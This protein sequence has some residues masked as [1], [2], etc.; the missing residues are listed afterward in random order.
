MGSLRYLV[1]LGAAVASSAAQA[2]LVDCRPPEQAP[3][4]VYLSEPEYTSTAFRNRPEMLGFFNR[5]HDYL[6]QRRDQ[7]MMGIAAVNFRVAR[8][9]GRVPAIDGS[10]FTDR[11]IRSMDG[12][13]VVVEVWGALD[14]VRAP[15]QAPQPTAQMN[16]LVVPVKR[17]RVP[18]SAS[19][20]GI[21]RFHYPDGSIVAADF[22][23][24]ISN[25]DLHAFV[26]AA[27]GVTAFDGDEYPLA[28]EMLCKARSQLLVTE[29]RLAA[30]AASQQQGRQIASLRQLL[31][32]LAR[33]SIESAR[34]RSG[35]PPT[36][37]VLHEPAEP[38]SAR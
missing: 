33:K 35:T 27:I 3:F 11:V 17:G 13:N 16:Y 6:D 30:R 1:V 26:A 9:Q 31:L 37:A 10:E 34:R 32:D 8:C 18:G 22:V 24:L 19:V 5:L 4:V 36:F 2:I 28:H 38:C 23:N 21:H 25:A 12:D 15:G 29:R 20:P 14:V 7:E